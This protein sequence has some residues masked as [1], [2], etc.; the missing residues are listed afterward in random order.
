MWRYVTNYK[1]MGATHFESLAVAVGGH[2]ALYPN[3][4]PTGS[5]LSAIHPDGAMFP[6]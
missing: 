6:A 2:I 1:A 4:V 3:P 5:N